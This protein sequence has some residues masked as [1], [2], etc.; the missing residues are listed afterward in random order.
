MKKI[1]FAIL[2]LS[3]SIF[4]YSQNCNSGT[5]ET[6]F[7]AAN[8]GYDETVTS[9]I[10]PGEYVTITNILENEYTFSSEIT[11]TP[12]YITIRKNSDD[13]IITQGTSPLTYTFVSGD[14]ADNSIKLIIHLDN[15]CDNTDNGNHT[16]TLLNVT[17]LPTCFEPENPRVSYLSNRRI[18]FYWDAPSS[19]SAPVDYEW[20]IG[21]PG[22]TPGTGAHVAMGSTGGPTNASSGETLTPTTA[23]E[24]AIRSDCGSGD[25]SIWLVTPSITTL[26]VDPPSNDFCDG[27]TYII[28][29][30]G[31]AVD[32]SDATSIPSSVVGGAGTNLDAEA[33]NGSANARDD[34][35]YSFIAQ[36]TDINIS[37]SPDFNGILTLFSGDCNSLIQ[38]ACSDANGGLVP[39][40][41]SIY[42]TGLTIGD[43]YYFRVYSQGFST[44]NP[45]FTFKLLSS[46]DPPD[47]DGDRYTSNGEIDCNDSDSAINPDATEIPGNSVDENCD[48]L[49]AWYQD[50]DNDGFGSSIVVESSNSNAGTGES[51]LSTDCNDNEPNAYPGNTEVCDG[52][53]NDCD[54]DIDDADSSVTGQT[55][56]YVDSDG[57]GYGDASDSGTLFCFNPGA[58]YSLSNDDCNDA[59]TAINPG[60]QEV[61]D[62]IDNDCDGDIDDADSSVTGQTT[63]HTD[64]DGDG[65]G[66]ENDSGTSFCSNPGAGYSIT[67][68]DCNDGNIAVNPGATEIPGNGIDDD[69]NPATE[70]TLSDDTFSLE[71]ILISPNPFKTSIRI[72]LKN[73]TGSE[74]LNI[75]MMDLNGRS[76]YN[77]NK[78]KAFNRII[79]LDNLQG[80]HQGIY[81][82]KIS[83][84][85]RS[86]VKRVVK[87]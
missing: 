13:S 46:Q 85:D 28:Q 45:D 87:I 37:L 86:V 73:N 21:L 17:N 53:D 75:Q 66:D 42:R 36:T 61:C 24:V 79:T 10:V 19:G 9:T 23:Y 82:I 78:P 55:T 30:F 12:D 69:C 40:E 58:G 54:G 4:T 5:Q 74:F 33:C 39:R 59:V 49:Y 67:N 32:G 72:Q 6:T 64:S 44:S 68:D 77:Y 35:W 63:Y 43:T 11:G 52:I 41:E 70:D 56:Y 34:V 81:F 15:T 83:N 47:L 62:G 8:T 27:A 26:A 48:G 60:A 2:V 14:V 76:I 22:F 16:I 20:E 84:L 29:E 71:Q 51:A 50:N 65:Y 18:D 38:L 57:D 7:N 25:F 31:K 80:L 1:T 3:H